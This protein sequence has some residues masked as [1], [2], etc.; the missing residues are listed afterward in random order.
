MSVSSCLF[1]FWKK[2]P[3]EDDFTIFLAHF[4]SVEKRQGILAAYDFLIN[5][6][7]GSLIYENGRLRVSEKSQFVQFQLE[8]LGDFLSR[9]AGEDS[10]GVGLRALDRLFRPEAGDSSEDV[11]DTLNIVIRYLVRNSFLTEADF[12]TYKE[13]HPDLRD[14]VMALENRLGSISTERKVQRVVEIRFSAPLANHPYHSEEI[15]HKER[16]KPSLDRFFTWLT[17]DYDWNWISCLKIDIWAGLIAL[18]PIT[19]WAVPLTSVVIDEF[20]NA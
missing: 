8:K 1:S 20:N 9:S 2:T 14:K 3:I 15:P 12:E 13:E 18:F 6:I 19:L 17:S 16:L 5:T 10:R 11:V 4:N 7:N